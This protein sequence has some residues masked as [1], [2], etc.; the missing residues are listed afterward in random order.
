MPGRRGR[1]SSAALRLGQE[2]ALDV[3]GDALGELR[4]QRAAPRGPG[5]TNQACMTLR[6]SYRAVQWRQNDFKDR[7]MSY[8][9]ATED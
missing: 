9:Y 5:R 4:R 8:T 2:T 7:T 1:A 6:R 3:R